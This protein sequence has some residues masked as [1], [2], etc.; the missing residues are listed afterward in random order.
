M[1]GIVARCYNTILVE[2]LWRAFN[3]DGVGVSVPPLP[4][5]MTP[6]HPAYFNHQ[7]A[8]MNSIHEALQRGSQG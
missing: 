5:K 3:V 4:G 7:G 1:G 2:G 6:L 8:L